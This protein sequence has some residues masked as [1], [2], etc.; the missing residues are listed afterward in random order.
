M[1]LRLYSSGYRLSRSCIKLVELNWIS[2]KHVQLQ[3][4]FQYESSASGLNCISWGLIK[5]LLI[6]PALYLLFANKISFHV[7]KIFLY[8]LWKL[9]SSEVKNFLSFLLL[10]NTKVANWHR[11]QFIADSLFDKLQLIKYWTTNAV[12]GLKHPWSSPN[13]IHHSQSVK[14]RTEEFAKTA[15]IC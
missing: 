2:W 5:C 3:L 6:K 14:G 10:H 7:S 13:Y 15:Y 11:I 12:L 9:L 4:V 8:I 1:C